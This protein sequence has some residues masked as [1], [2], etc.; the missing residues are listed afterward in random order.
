MSTLAQI[1]GRVQR[2]LDRL[3]VTTTEDADV[4]ALINEIIREDICADHLWPSME[5]VY[6]MNVTASVSLYAWPNPDNFKDCDNFKIRYE[7]TDE[8]VP[9]LEEDPGVLLDTSRYPETDE[10]RPRVWAVAGEAFRIRP[11]PDASTYSLRVKVWEYPG[12]LTTDGATNWFTVNKPKLVIMGA[13]M[14]GALYYGEAQDA[15][16]WQALY[17]DELGKATNTDKRSQLPARPTFKP[18]LAAGRSLS[19]VPGSSYWGT[20]IRGAYS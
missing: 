12:Y 19:N 2:N 20:R 1:R 3:Q 7:T 8:Y 18:S 11:I 15:A 10:D 14:L 9:L 4:D 16:A 13:T 5:A 17:R 6:T